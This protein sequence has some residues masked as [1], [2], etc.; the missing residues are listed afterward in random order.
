[1]PTDQSLLSVLIRFSRTLVGRFDVSGVLYELS[2]SV[3]EVLGAAGAGVSLSDGKGGLQFATSTTEAVAHIEAVQTRS[4]GGPCHRAFETGAAVLVDDLDAD[5]EPSWA[6]YRSVAA[7][8]GFRSVAGIPMNAGG[9]RIGALNLYDAKPRKWS[10][11]DVATA[12]VFADIATSYVVHAT[13]LDK[14]QQVNVQLQH[15]VDNRVVIEQAKGLLAGERAISVDQALA[16]LR[17]H[18]RNRNV[19]LRSVADAVVNL[20]LRPGTDD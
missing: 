2:D 5:T 7:A 10:A 14:A 8:E 11:D 6:E 4:A 12:Q 1:M 17:S 18:A 13:D 9:R 20:G 16:V 19:T 3:V 15:A